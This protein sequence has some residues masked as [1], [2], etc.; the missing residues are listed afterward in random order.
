MTKWLFTEIDTA[1]ILRVHQIQSGMPGQQPINSVLV[2]TC[3]LSGVQWF[4]VNT[5]ETRDRMEG[6]R[7]ERLK[8]VCFVRRNKVAIVLRKMTSE[9]RILF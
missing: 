4:S 8:L 9:I 2:Y 3:L 1:I 5:F 6:I 7:R